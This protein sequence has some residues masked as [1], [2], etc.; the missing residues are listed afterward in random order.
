MDRNVPF[1]NNCLYNR[2]YI[3]DF[4]YAEKILQALKNINNKRK[5]FE[6]RMLFLYVSLSLIQSVCFSDALLI[7]ISEPKAF[8]QRMLF[9][10]EFVPK[11]YVIYDRTVIDLVDPIIDITTTQ[12][13]CIMPY[14]MLRFCILVSDSCLV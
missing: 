7:Q 10:C 1:R 6:Q 12:N 3:T 13:S 5:V 9:L 2:I 14:I 4:L 8:K 11:S